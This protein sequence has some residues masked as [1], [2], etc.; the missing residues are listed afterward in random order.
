MLLKA[1]L[2]RSSSEANSRVSSEA[3]MA[4]HPLGFCPLHKGEKSPKL[5]SSA[6]ALKGAIAVD[7]KGKGGAFSLIG[8]ISIMTRLT[9]PR[10]NPPEKRFVKAVWRAP[11]LVGAERC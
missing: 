6:L 9:I 2:Q 5:R 3:G 11:R 1:Y 7:A 10:A 4:L 8:P